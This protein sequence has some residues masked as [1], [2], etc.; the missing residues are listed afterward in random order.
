MRKEHVILLTL[1]TLIVFLAGVGVGYEM[2]EPKTITVTK[3]E[4]VEVPAVKHVFM[5]HEIEEI[6]HEVA[7]EHEYE[8]GVYDCE[9]FSHELVRRLEIRGYDADYVVGRH[10]SAGRHAW[11]RAT[12]YVEATNGHIIP[13]EEFKRNYTIQSVFEN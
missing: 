3:F 9:E 12:I 4:Y 11:V 13:P 2:Y 7:T 1:I 10:A 8:F 5:R 6:A